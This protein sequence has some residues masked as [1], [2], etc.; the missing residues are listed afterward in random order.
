M[1]G[2]AGWYDVRVRI[3]PAAEGEPEV[4]SPQFEALEPVAGQSVENNPGRW[5]SFL[6]GRGIRP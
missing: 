3:Y 2:Q 1:T 4:S 5:L 6:A